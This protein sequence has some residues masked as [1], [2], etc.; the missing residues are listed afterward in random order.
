MVS[1]ALRN[2]TWSIV[3]VLRIYLR[4]K[5]VMLGKK[6]GPVVVVVDESV[7]RAIQDRGLSMRFSYG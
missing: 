2:L 4:V 3:A 1:M 5:S 7:A 6:G